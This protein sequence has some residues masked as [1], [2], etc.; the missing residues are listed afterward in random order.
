[1][2]LISFN[3]SWMILNIFLAVIPLI[4]GWVFYLTKNKILFYLAGIVWLLFVPNTI[5]L[6]TDLINLI[7]QWGLTETAD[8]LVL[9]F[10][11]SVLLI[12]GFITY[13]LS[14]YPFELFVEKNLNRFL[15]LSVIRVLIIFNFIIAFGITLGR[16]E[17]VNS[18]DVLMNPLSIVD[19]SLNII[20][21]VRLLMLTILFGIFANLLYFTFGGIFIK[22]I[23]I[24]FRLF[25]KKQL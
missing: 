22:Y 23:K 7:N 24:Y 25:V 19:S 9:I 14:L 17:R 3:F 11:Y 10:Q 13:I 15:N 12:I 21:S 8:K 4:F 16:V 6:F 2:D 1:M 20:F 18:W 5:Y